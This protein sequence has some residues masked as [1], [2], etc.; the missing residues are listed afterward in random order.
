MLIIQK[1]PENDILII[2]DDI[3][4]NFIEIFQKEHRIYPTDI[5]CGTFMFFLIIKFR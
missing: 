2:D 4:H 3:I 5:I 1:Y